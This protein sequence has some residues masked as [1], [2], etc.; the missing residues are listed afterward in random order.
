[1]LRAKD[2]TAEL[3]DTPNWPSGLD[4]HKREGIQILGDLVEITRNARMAGL[5]DR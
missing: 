1:M 2:E 3:D 5:L 4:L